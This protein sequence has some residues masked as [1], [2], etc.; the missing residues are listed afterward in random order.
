MTENV[1]SLIKE[2]IVTDMLHGQGE[3][4]DRQSPL[5]ELGVIESLSMVRLLDFV[6]HRFGVKVPDTELLPE[7]FETLEAITA[8]VTRYLGSAPV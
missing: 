6:E 3:G 8:L 2:F 4:L 5:L 7:N 1:L